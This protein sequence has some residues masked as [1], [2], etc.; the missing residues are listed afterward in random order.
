M[1]GY[2]RATVTIS[3]EEYRRLHQADMKRRFQQHTKSKAKIDGH[4]S[5]MTNTLKGMESRQQQ[6]E[7]ALLDLGQDFDWI[8]AEMRDDILAHNARCYQ[9]LATMIEE[10]NSDANVSLEL[11]SQRFAEE[12]QSEREQYL[13]HLQSLSQ[14]LDTYERREGS[15]AEAAR[16]WL[17][18]SAAM[19]DFIRQQL[20]HERFLPGRLSRILD[21]LNFAQN[22]LAAGFFE[23]SLQTSQQAFLQLS[24]LHYELEQRT[25][26][27]Q[28]EYARA[29]GAL[30]Q[31]IAELELNSSVNALGLE[32]EQLPEQVDLDYWSNGRYRELLDKCRHLLA[33]LSREQRSISTAEL[34]QTYKELLPVVVE[35]FESIIYEARLN[36]L[37]SQLRMN[38]AERALQALE[39][40]GFRL[41][42]SGYANQD[43]R[44]AFKAQ[45]ENADGSQV[46]I[47]ILPTDR[48]KQDLSNEL[49][50][51]T[52][53][54]YLKTENEA[55][56]QWQELCRTLNQYD[57]H[58]SRPEIRATPATSVTQA[59]N[60]PRINDV[61]VPSQRRHDV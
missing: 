11:L 14:R 3:E 4:T 9:S 1:S 30:T 24:E 29:Q 52:N 17:R 41:N 53:H 54:P 27:W 35:R 56:L 15:K 7:Q 60:S 6:L 36:A 8:G 34:K 12:L 31:F 49:V 21:G 61:A 48:T 33:L 59:E 10:T 23:S 18:Q 45:L 32:G 57:L 40:Q 22:N 5:D 42:K 39:I 37:N 43:M 2:K 13:H 25:V 20:D 55:R 38:I 58:V 46:L 44:S 50:V 47:E 51:V 16:Q 19:A 26:E 28:T